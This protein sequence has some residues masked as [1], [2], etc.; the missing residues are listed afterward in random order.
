MDSHDVV[1]VGAGLAGLTCAVELTRR[2]LDV[3]V[4]EAADDVGGRIR[5][6]AV[7]DMLLDRGFQLLNP[8]Y[9]AL[10]GIVNVPALDLHRFEAG[11]VVASGS[12]RTVLADPL[13]SPRDALRALS[14]A[15]GSLAEK[16]RFA[17]YAVRCALAPSRRLRSLDDI[18]Y[19][20]ALD[21]A[22]VTG[23]LRTAVLEPFLAG[24]LGEDA[25]E[26][27]RRFVDMLLRTFARGVPGLPAA[28]MQAMPEQIAR[29]LPA[30]RLQLH[31]RVDAVQAGVARGPGGEW[32]GRGVV[33]ATDAVAAAGL[34]G[35]PAPTMRG[36]TT[37]YHRAARSPAS[38]RLLHVDGDRRGPV[39]NTAVVSDVAPTYCRDGALIASTVLGA[40]DS[41]GTVVAVERQL[42]QIYGADVAEWQLVATYPIPHALPAMLPPLDMR[43][44][45]TV[46]GGLFVAGDHRDT[47]SIQGAIVSGRRAA[48]A[49]RRALGSPAVGS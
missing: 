47:A 40:D 26:T 13:R 2:G 30:G 32:R 34:T 29:L 19:G 42:A 1:V 45:V 27:S 46:D 28:G 23:R 16:A 35:L 38:R 22:H 9:P 4:V 31:A 6:D 41:A 10:R 12:G 24:V 14:P 11:V 33:V 48:T 18:S 7:D 8:A 43:Q 21:T 15:T 25:Q 5:T 36:L 44:P 49:V 20:A 17:P 3:M 39:V 37:F